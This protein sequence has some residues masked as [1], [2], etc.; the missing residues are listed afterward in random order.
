MTL[1]HPQDP[2]SLREAVFEDFTA[3]GRKSVAAA[4]GVASGTLSRYEDLGENGL[5]I[6]AQLVDQF[7]RMFHGAPAA[8]IARHFAAVAGGVF[9]PAT[10]AP[11]SPTEACSAIAAGAAMLTGQPL[12]AIDPTGLGGAA[13]T[14][15]ERAQLP[16]RAA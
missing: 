11:R 3:A 4:L 2:N 7:C 16:K 15:A 1:P 10:T 9:A 6:P 12:A 5:R 14:S 8:I 13:L